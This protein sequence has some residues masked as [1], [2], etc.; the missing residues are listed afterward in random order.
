MRHHLVTQAL[1]VAAKWRHSHPAQRAMSNRQL[2][3]LASMRIKHTEAALF[4]ASIEATNTPIGLFRL[5]SA[6]GSI[7]V[8]RELQNPPSGSFALNQ[9]AEE[10]V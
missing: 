1:E 3:T 4:F 6:S 7:D 8:A 10:Q 5:S 9:Q 2:L